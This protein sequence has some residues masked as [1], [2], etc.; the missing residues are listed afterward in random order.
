MYDCQ[1]IFKDCLLWSEIQRETKKEEENGR[2]GWYKIPRNSVRL[3]R[4]EMSLLG[5]SRLVG[6]L[7]LY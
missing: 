7:I 3:E 1:T 5:E 6:C 4:N 2:Q